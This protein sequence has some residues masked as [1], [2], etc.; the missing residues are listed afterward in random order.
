[1]T[2]KTK[3]I[4][5]IATTLVLVV[6]LTPAIIDLIQWLYLGD[7]S[8]FIYSGG[9]QLLVAI[10]ISSLAALGYVVNLE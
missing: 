2:K 4:V 3:L 5:N 8:I 1:M 7:E 9:Y 10:L 6:L